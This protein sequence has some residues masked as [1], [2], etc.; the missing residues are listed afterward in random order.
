MSYTEQEEI[1]IRTLWQNK[2]DHWPAEYPS[3]MRLIEGTHE[4]RNDLNLP[5]PGDPE[6]MPLIDGFFTQLMENFECERTAE[7]SEDRQEILGERALLVQV[8][9][10]KLAEKKID[11]MQ[12]LGPAISAAVTIY[13]QLRDITPT[14]SRR[15]C[16]KTTGVSAHT[17]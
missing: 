9:T 5:K 3:L 12:G 8:A 4:P 6:L 7:T 10:A 2:K 11:R 1:R 15:T 14:V 17:R 16:T 13:K